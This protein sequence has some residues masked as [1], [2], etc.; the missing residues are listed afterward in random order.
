MPRCATSS[1]PCLLLTA[2]VKAPFSWPKSSVSRNSRESAGAVQVDER[3]V[4]RA[5]RSGAASAPAR[6]CRCRSRPGSG[7][8]CSTPAAVARPRPAAGSRPTCPVNGIDGLA[9]PR[10]RDRPP[11]GAARAASRAAGA[12]SPASAGSSTGLVRNCSAPSLTA[13]T[14]RSIERVARQDHH[15]HGRVDLADPGQAARARSPSGSMWSSTQRRRGDTRARAAPRRRRSRPPRP[16]SPALSRKSRTPNRIAG[17][18]VD[19][20]DLGHAASPFSRR[21]LSHGR[22]RG[23]W[24]GRLR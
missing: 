12:A 19:D 21:A 2:P 9:A 22:R 3:L 16:R 15:R 7:S 24:L 10:A 13:R 1:S 11:G 17:L 20:Q 8:G 4:A 23:W 18:V 6:P 14:A 5:G